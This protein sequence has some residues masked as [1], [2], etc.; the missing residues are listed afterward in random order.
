M[1]RHDDKAT[2]PDARQLDESPAS[3]LEPTA[4]RAAEQADADKNL[5][6]AD[7]D[8]KQADKA[9]KGRTAK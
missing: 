6:D 7:T 8:T 2:E 9:A 4:V 3:P 5:P 1:T